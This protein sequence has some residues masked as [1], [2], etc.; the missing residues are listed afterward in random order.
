MIS[1]TPK[2]SAYRRNYQAKKKADQFW[3]DLTIMAEK[4]GKIAAI[5][6]RRNPF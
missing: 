4:S 2:T 6:V 3:T 1:N 5:D